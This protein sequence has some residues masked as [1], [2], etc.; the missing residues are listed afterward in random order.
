VWGDFGSKK[1]RAGYPASDRWG[2]GIHFASA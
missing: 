2:V 1:S